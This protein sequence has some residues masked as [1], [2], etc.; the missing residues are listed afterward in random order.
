MIAD[1]VHHETFR[2]VIAAASS[3]CN[4]CK[5]WVAMA[6]LDKDFRRHR[7]GALDTEVGMRGRDGEGVSENGQK[8]NK[9]KDEEVG[10]GNG[11]G[12]GGE[13]GFKWRLACRYSPCGMVSQYVLYAKALGWDQERGAWEP[14]LNGRRALEIK[15]WRVIETGG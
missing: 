5:M 2:D 11:S 4:L 3:G 15:F 8:S 14:Y 13:G 6:K 9:P 7:E 10:G 1:L 12:H